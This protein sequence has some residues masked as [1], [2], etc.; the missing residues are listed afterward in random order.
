[1]HHVGVLPSICTNKDDEDA[2]QL[3]ADLGAGK[4]PPLPVEQ[5]NATSPDDTAGLDKIRS[6]C[7]V[8]HSERTVD[9]QVALRLLTQPRLYARAVA[10]AEPIGKASATLPD[11]SL[12]PP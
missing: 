9:L 5:R 4:L 7:P 11:L 8:Y 1:L 2:T 12:T 10:L 6:A 3:L